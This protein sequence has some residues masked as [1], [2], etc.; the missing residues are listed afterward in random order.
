LKAVGQ[1]LREILRVVPGMRSE[2]S[3][4]E[5]NAN[6]T[7]R[8]L[9][10]SACGVVNLISRT[11]EEQAGALSASQGVGFSRSRYDFSFGE[12]LQHSRY[13]VAG[14]LRD[15]ESARETNITTEN[16]GQLR[17][18]ATRE[19]ENGYLRASFKYLNDGVPMD[20]TR[21][22]LRNL[23]AARLVMC[24]KARTYRGV[25]QCAAGSKY[26]HNMFSSVC[27]TIGLVR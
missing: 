10:I 24:N 12:L 3:G 21:Q 9:P 18:N 14:F 4:G 8:G 27:R 17:A 26:L 23:R 2:S 15:G 25:H 13:F 1:T 16:G 20:T 7:V 11:G 6:I 19:F 5:G 22:C